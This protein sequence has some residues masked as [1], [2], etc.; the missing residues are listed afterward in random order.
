[1][2]LL[3]W[4]EDGPYFFVLAVVAVDALSRSFVNRSL[5]VSVRRQRKGGY[6]YGQR[7]VGSGPGHPLVTPSHPL[8]LVRSPC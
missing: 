3:C 6:E 4:L 1:M 7:L 5:T 8:T 2:T